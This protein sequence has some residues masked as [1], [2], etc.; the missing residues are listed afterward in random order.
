MSV[1]KRSREDDRQVE[2]EA[3]MLLSRF[4]DTV[5][6]PSNHLHINDFE[7]MTCN[8]RFPS[9]QALGGH[10]A[11]HNKR[12]RLL[13]EFL[14]ET[15]KN[16]LHKCS[17]CGVE[18][19][20]GQALGGH[21]RRHRDEINKITTHEKTMIPILNK[22]NSSKRIFCLDLNLNPRDDNVDFKLWPTTPIASPVLRI[23]I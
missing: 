10:R 7:C 19:S 23:F 11:S 13:G 1:P 9:F 5:S 20:L 18:F 3:L 15:K 6:T 21:M 16:K 17:I 2:A 22:S 12:P 14:V 8:K 4:N